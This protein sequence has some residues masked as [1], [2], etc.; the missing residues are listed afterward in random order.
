MNLQEALIKAGLK[1]TP[2]KEG[3]NFDALRGKQCFGQYLSDPNVFSTADLHA[4]AKAAVGVTRA[5][6][7]IVLP[8]GT[9]VESKRDVALIDDATGAHVNTVSPDYNLVQDKDLILEMAGAIEERGLVPVG[10]VRQTSHRFQASVVMADPDFRI[11]LLK[12]HD[13]FIASGFSLTNSYTSDLG[14]HVEA[15]GIDTFCINYNPWGKTVKELS[16]TH[17]HPGDLTKQVKVVLDAALDAAPKVQR[18]YDERHEI[19]LQKKEV[20]F[21][22]AGVGFTEAAT[23]F[24]EKMLP[25][26]EP[27]TKVKLTA[28]TL[29]MAATSFVT[30]ISNTSPLT[31]RELS[32]KAMKLLTGDLQKIQERG[33]ETVREWDEA[34]KKS[35]AR[36]EKK[37][38]VAPVI[39]RNG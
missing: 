28:T 16:L 10:S 6:M 39:P 33:R 20:P 2:P 29:N 12:S 18:L 1:F 19:V 7:N 25:A 11:Q 23:D 9:Q 27:E 24:M 8:N 36:A 3:Y 32:R 37:Q 21:L 13:R 15:A 4:R 26:L 31:L 34:R 30:H 5:P 35:A 14:I 38:A 17:L 22:L